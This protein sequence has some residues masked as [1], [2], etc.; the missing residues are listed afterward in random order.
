MKL[1]GVE[2]SINLV[3]RITKVITGVGDTIVIGSFAA[4][5]EGVIRRVRVSG[6]NN[7]S[8]LTVAFAESDCFTS[9]DVDSIAVI[10]AYQISEPRTTMKDDS[11][12]YVLD[13]SAGDLYYNLASQASERSRSYG[14]MFYA[15]YTDD[16]SPTTV[17][18]KLDIE[19]IV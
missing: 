8:H 19:P 9:G 15:V 4:P 14:E 11:T 18:I 6:E 16:S 10:A 2:G 1:K 5:K 12:L 7:L 17:A 3:K 13:E